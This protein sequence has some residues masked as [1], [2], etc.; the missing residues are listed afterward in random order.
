MLSK[1]KVKVLENSMSLTSYFFVAHT[2]L[3]TCRA[4]KRAHNSLMNESSAALH[5]IE[6]YQRL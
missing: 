5:G 6:P 4:P 3:T 2:V 1:K